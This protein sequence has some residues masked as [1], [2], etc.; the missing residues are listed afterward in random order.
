MMIEVPMQIITSTGVI[1]QLNLN[2]VLA[3]TSIANGGIKKLY[4]KI[5]DPYLRSTLPYIDY[6]VKVRFLVWLC[7]PTADIDNTTPCSKYVLDSMQTAGVLINDNQKTIKEVDFVFMGRVKKRYNGDYGRCI[8]HV[9][10][11]D[12]VGTEFAQFVKTH[13][14]VLKD[15]FRAP[16]T[17]R[18]YN[19]KKTS[20]RKK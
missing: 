6:P 5:V 1:K 7:T 8:M 16:K 12:A 13:K 15:E 2:K 20:R 9:E 19:N 11:S 14:P 18:K 10:R 4:R 3:N 17:K